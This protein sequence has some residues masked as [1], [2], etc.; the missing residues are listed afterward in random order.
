MKKI[1]F[2]GDSHTWGEGASGLAESFNPPV[3]G[4]EKRF[5]GFEYPSYVN[6]VRKA[7]LDKTNSVNHEYNCNTFK[8]EYETEYGCVCVD[9]IP[10]N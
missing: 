4:G 2:T 5:S 9:S 10:L 8:G 1:C 6:L 7:V 3:V